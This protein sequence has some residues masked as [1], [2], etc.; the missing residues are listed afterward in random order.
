M[1][2]ELKTKIRLISNRRNRTLLSLVSPGCFSLSH[3]DLIP[4]F[5]SNSK[6]ELILHFYKN[7][8]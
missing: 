7:K 5:K 4:Q 8:Y 2:V 1:I 3:T 6:P